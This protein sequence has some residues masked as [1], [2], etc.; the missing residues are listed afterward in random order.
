MADKAPPPIESLP[1]PL[2]PQR[3]GR[4]GMGR[5]VLCVVGLVVLGALP[6]S[7]APFVSPRDDPMS[8]FAI[9]GSFLLL[10]ALGAAMAAWTVGGPGFIAIRGVTAIGVGMVLA[11]GSLVAVDAFSYSFGRILLLPSFLTLTSLWFAGSY[12]LSLVL[13]TVGEIYF[14]QFVAADEPTTPVRQFR[15]VDLMIA[16]VGVIL[17]SAV[18]G[19]SLPYFTTPVPGDGIERGLFEAAQFAGMFAV[20]TLLILAAGLLCGRGSLGAILSG[21]AGVAIVAIVTMLLLLGK[22]G[23]HVDLPAMSAALAAAALDGY[24][25]LVL[26]VVLMR[27]LVPTGGE[28][29]VSIDEK[30]NIPPE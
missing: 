11:W 9:T 3:Q 25:F 1:N 26:C 15:I 16:S 21:G 24:F 4:G 29:A 10:S 27:T 8:V 14:R 30:Y 13:G 5:I 7:C 18:V 6:L 12:V 28:V 23:P 20:P 2:A 22:G 17:S 19:W